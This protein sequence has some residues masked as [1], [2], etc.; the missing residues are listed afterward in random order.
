MIK[1]DGYCQ[2]SINYN[3][4]CHSEIK[5]IKSSAN[6][7]PLHIFRLPV[8][9]ME[10]IDY[11]QPFTWSRKTGYKFRKIK[12]KREVFNYEKLQ[13]TLQRDEG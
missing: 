2:V 4:V 1:Y 8:H 10:I 11:G 7:K 12:P 9:V 5:K 6:T 13:L 3:I